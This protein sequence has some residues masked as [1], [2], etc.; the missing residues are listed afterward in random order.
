[1]KYQNIRTEKKKGCGRKG[2]SLLM[3]GTMAVSML[4]AVP[5]NAA[6]L[7]EPT[8][9]AVELAGREKAESGSLESLLAEE[10][11]T[12]DPAVSAEPETTTAAET[13]TSSAEA[14]S[15]EHRGSFH[16]REYSCFFGGADR[17]TAGDRRSVTDTS[18]RD[19]ARGDTA[20]RNTPGRDD[21]G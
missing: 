10:N 21:S 14:S 4:P 6:E 18:C 3:A 2:I 13:T 8:S 12:S 17:D 1:M 19:T 7:A 16:F 20:E 9:A 15:R 5:A 11:E